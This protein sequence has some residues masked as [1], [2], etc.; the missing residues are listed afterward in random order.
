M[1]FEDQAFIVTGGASGMGRAT[2]TLLAKNGANVVIA[3]INTDAGT[4]VAESIGD[5][6]V[7]EETDLRSLDS[8]RSTVS[9]TEE[10]FGKINGLA[11]VAA[12][13]PVVSFLDTTPEQWE[14]MDA[15]NLRGSFFMAQA[16]AQSM[17]R[18]GT[19]GAIVNVASGAAYRP[20]EGQAAY[21][22][23]K[24]GVTAM[25]RTMAAELAQHRIRVN[26]MAPGH[27]ASETIRG[28]LTE[29]QL[30]E[31][32]ATL[33]PK[34]WMEPEEVA[35]A[36]VFLLSD[37]SHMMTGAFLNVNMGNFMPH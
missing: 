6:A 17:I 35:Q 22:A 11:N 36:I 19:E 5:K 1:S 3:D 16:V 9:R 31:I 33:F 4:R 18:T 8:I 26:V 37:T 34:R 13:Y 28:N 20:V 21:T 12:V 10:R 23:T 2:A 32:G 30:Q 14:E 29:E 24:G 7:L 27:T 15:V 25:T